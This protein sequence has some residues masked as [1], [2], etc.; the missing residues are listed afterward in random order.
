MHEFT[1]R[2]GMSALRLV[3]TFAQSGL[4]RFMSECEICRMSKGNIN[5]AR[6]LVANV[7]F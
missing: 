2:T 3:F 4:G 5:L 7:L 6:G 1:V